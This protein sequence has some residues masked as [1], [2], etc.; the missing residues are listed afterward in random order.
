MFFRILKK[1]LK[2]KKTMN[3]II[4]LFVILATM[5]VASSVKPGDT[6]LLDHNG[7]QLA[8]TVAGSGKDAS[9]G[10]DFLG[11]PR[12]LIHPN[13]YTKL[14]ENAIKYGDGREIRMGFSCEEDGRLLTITNTGSAL[15]ESEL[16]H[17][18]DSFWRSSNAGDKSG[19]CLGLYIC[20]QLMR[21]MGGDIFA[22]IRENEFCVSVVFSPFFNNLWTYIFEYDTILY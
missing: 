5:F 8:L 21:K 13:D 9:L 15:P 22:E 18:F 10:S 12:F 20:R 4:L 16:L 14:M 17:I 11:N 7:T 3:I 19:S 1:D 2:H 6:I